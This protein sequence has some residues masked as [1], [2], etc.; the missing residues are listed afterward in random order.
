[1]PRLAINQHIINIE[2][3]IIRIL[4]WLPE[5]GHLGVRHPLTWSFAERLRQMPRLLYTHATDEK[6]P[7]TRI[8]VESIR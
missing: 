6:R 5:C 7:S 4:E 3:I 8:E 1:M 2:G